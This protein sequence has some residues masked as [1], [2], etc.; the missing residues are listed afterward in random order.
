MWNFIRDKKSR[1]F[2]RFW[3]AQLI[4]QS[5]DRVYQLALLGLM[6]IRYPGSVTAITNMLSFTIIPVF[7]IGPI[8]GVYIDRWDRRTTL[9]I[10]DFIRG[11]LVL[12]TA[13]YLVHLSVIWP[14]YVVVF[15]I[16]SLSRFYV[17]A[18]MSFIPEIVHEEHLL[19]AN[20]LSTTTGMIALVLGGLLGAYIV[21]YTGPFGGFCGGSIGYFLSAVLV[22]SI[23]TLRH[24]LPNKS[25]II[26]GTKEI[27]QT[28]KS[29]WHE[30]IDGI[31]YIRSVKEISL[32]FWMMTILL[33]AAGAIYVVIIV[34]IQ[35]AF[36]SLTKDLGLLAVSLGIGAFLGSLAYG[37]WGAK[38]AAFKAIF[39]SLILGGAMVVLFASMVE[40]THNRLLAMGLSFVLGF[41]IGPATIASNTLINKVCAMEMSGKVFT[42]LEIVMYL[43][44]WVAMQMSSFLS[45]FLHIQRLWILITVGGIFMIVGL[46][47]LFKFNP[48][49]NREA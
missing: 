15:V 43:A 25:E 8:A 14:M 21:E 2:F 30:I 49:K 31:R 7:I 11:L 32:I 48:V 27:L 33:A 3:F 10:C 46:V 18:K 9:F 29:V 5:G 16:F 37:R 17:P 1:D 47:G 45:D 42:A 34:F 41:V 22:F 26:A 24:R 19:I 12:L 28:E 35:Q 13:F 4:S 44:F 6:A 38:I 20:S 40:T 36:H 23:A 39:W